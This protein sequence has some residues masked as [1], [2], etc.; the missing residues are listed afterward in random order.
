[1]RAIW[2]AWKRAAGL[3][4]GNV[5]AVMVVNFV[6]VLAC[7]PLVT[8]GPGVFAAYRWMAEMV[9]GRDDSWVAYSGYF[10]RLF[11]RGLLWS[12][13]CAALLLLAYINLQVWPRFLPPMGMAVVQVFWLYV[14]IFFLAMQPF[15]FQALAKEELGLL[16]SFRRAAWHVI[17]NPLFSHAFLI[18]PAIALLIATQTQTWTMLFL[19]ATVLLFAAV[20]ADEVPWKYGQANPKDRPSEED[21]L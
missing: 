12:V 6:T 11:L 20:M 19:I 9:A 13:I 16:V 3:L 14:I 2:T 7:V 18:I 10:R 21:V 4:W 1:M 8:I 15:V 5:I 17:A